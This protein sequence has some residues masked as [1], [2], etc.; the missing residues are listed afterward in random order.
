M[1]TRPQSLKPHPV[2]VAGYATAAW[3]VGSVSIGHHGTFHLPP[4][5]K[6][7]SSPHTVPQRSPRNSPRFFK[8][9]TF[10]GIE[11]GKTGQIIRTADRWKVNT[12]TC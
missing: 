10:P 5:E 6:I 4:G 11:V 1:N 2:V 9:H 3:P 12:A 7:F 8:E